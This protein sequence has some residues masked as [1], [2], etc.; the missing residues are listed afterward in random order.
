LGLL[1]LSVPWG[2]GGLIVV[3]V[4]VFLYAAS[5]ILPIERNHLD[6]MNSA[7]AFFPSV[8]IAWGAWCMR[9]GVRYKTA[10]AASI[11][12]C[13]PLASPC[14]YVGIPFGIWAIV[15]LRRPDVR[16]AF[17]SIK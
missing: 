7:L 2:I 4:L 8:Y 1:L 12:A 15:V 6:S 10:L 11:L 3:I 9:R 14:L 17:G 5:Y 13:I 16:A